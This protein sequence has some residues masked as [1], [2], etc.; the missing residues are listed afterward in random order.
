[1][2][3][4]PTK[5]S[6]VMVNPSRNGTYKGDVLVYKERRVSINVSYVR[7]WGTSLANA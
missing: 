2:K 3:K 7:L 6:L 5:N 4:N 1:M